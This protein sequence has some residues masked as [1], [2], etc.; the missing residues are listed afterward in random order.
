MADNNTLI[1]EDRMRCISIWILLLP[2][3]LASVVACSGMRVGVS[4][5]VAGEIALSLRP[6][7]PEGASPMAIDSVSGTGEVELALGDLMMIVSWSTT[8]TE[9][10]VGERY[11]CHVVTVRAPT[12]RWHGALG[13][14]ERCIRDH[15]A[16]DPGSQ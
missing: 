13:D 10:D 15:G 1:P 14:D 5:Q 7:A 16:F 4:L 3:V 2:L 11:T 9:S 8:N 12:G 6:Q